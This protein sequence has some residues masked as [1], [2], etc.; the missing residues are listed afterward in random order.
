[1]LTLI[2]LT[3]C[4]S[5]S[6][7]MAPE[8]AADTGTLAPAD[9]EDTGPEE[10]D[11]GNPQPQA[12]VATLALRSVTGTWCHESVTETGIELTWEPDFAADLAACPGCDRLFLVCTETLDVCGG[13][14]RLPGPNIRGVAFTGDRA[15]V[16]DLRDGSWTYL[17]SGWHRGPS[18]SYIYENEG[19]EFTGI[20]E[21]VDQEF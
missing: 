19:L 15:D 21:M 5:G 20:V 11:T 18:F 7:P 16:Y 13:V 4:T 6:L 3:A 12:W 9:T 14:V 8:D 10:V 17:G 1:M 2:F